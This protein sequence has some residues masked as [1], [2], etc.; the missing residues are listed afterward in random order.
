VDHFKSINDAYGHAAGDYLLQSL[1]TCTEQ[2]MRISDFL[3]RYGGEEFVI[4]LPETDQAGVLRLAKRIRRRVEKLETVYQDQ[5]I[6]MTV[7]LGVTNL[8]ESDDEKTLFTRADEALYRAKRDGRN[9]IRVASPS[10]D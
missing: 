3:F 9:C 1:T 6:Q 4:I 10:Q 7:S 5:T 8:R 2:S